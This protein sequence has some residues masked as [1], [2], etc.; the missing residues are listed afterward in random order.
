MPRR[1]LAARAILVIV[2]LD[3]YSL[4]KFFGLPLRK[5]DGQFRAGC[6]Y[7]PCVSGLNLKPQRLC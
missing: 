1:V 2:S 5:I 3:V 7:A 6:K 4:S